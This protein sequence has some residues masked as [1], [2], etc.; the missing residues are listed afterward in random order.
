VSDASW[1]EELRQAMGHCASALVAYRTDLIES[2]GDS[3]C[4][5]GPGPLPDD[6]ARL[7]QLEQMHDTLR[8]AYGDG[9][10]AVSG[11]SRSAV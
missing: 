1:L 6:V 4:G 11:G 5:I 10:K 9:L 8:R 2:L 7:E 3:L